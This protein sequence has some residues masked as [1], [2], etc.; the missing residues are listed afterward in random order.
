MQP[1]PP[2]W[3]R[4]GAQGYVAW[5]GVQWRG[6][7]LDDDIL[8]YAPSMSDNSTEDLT[9]DPSQNTNVTDDIG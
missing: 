5:F 2:E 7:R 9:Q 4:F 6:Q 1:S 8:S 3:S